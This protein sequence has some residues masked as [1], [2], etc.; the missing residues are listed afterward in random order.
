M[1]DANYLRQPKTIDPAAMAAAGM[2]VAYDELEQQGRSSR[3]L[4][5]HPCS[6]MATQTSYQMMPIEQSAMGYIPTHPMATPAAYSEYASPASFSPMLTPYDNYANQSSYMDAG[7][8]YSTPF[9]ASV[10]SN[11]Y[12]DMG[13][14]QTSAPMDYT[15]AAFSSDVMDSSL[16]S[17]LDWDHF[18]AHGFNATT[19]PPTPDSFLPI[20]HPDLSFQTEEAIPYH[21]LSEPE[22]EGEVLVGM[23]LYDAPEKS[24]VIDPELEN[25][26]ALMLSQFLGPACRQQEPV[27]KGLKLEETWNPPASDDEEDDEAED[28]DEAPAEVD[29]T[30]G[31]LT[32]SCVGDDSPLGNE[33]TAQM[34][35]YQMNLWP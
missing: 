33:L 3:P 9:D 18:A 7:A 31:S 30:E 26:R 21:S 4:S 22:P 11:V 12:S 16:Y 10:P 25:Y 19:A 8:F 34:G 15:T 35:Q 23:G 5:W 1:N 28:D 14:S 20:Q 24:P 17:Q 2:G 13:I 29:C 32:T 27:R 6:Q